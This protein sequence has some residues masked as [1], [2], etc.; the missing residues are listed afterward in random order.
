MILF[1]V[2]WIQIPYG[3]SAIYRCSLKQSGSH[4]VWGDS[5]FTLRI[6]L[7]SEGISED[8]NLSSLHHWREITLQLHLCILFKLIQVA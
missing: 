4:E 3:V 1:H 6:N 8:P 7:E 5:L 2:S